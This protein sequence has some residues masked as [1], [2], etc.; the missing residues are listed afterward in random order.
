MCVF[1][2]NFALKEVYLCRA[3]ASTDE[4]RW[5]TKRSVVEMRAIASIALAACAAAQCSVRLIN[6]L[7]QSA[8]LST[9]GGSEVSQAAA[10]S[11]AAYSPVSCDTTSL[12]LTPNG[13]QAITV[14]IF[15]LAPATPAASVIAYT[16]G[17]GQAAGA[18]VLDQTSLLPVGPE[19]IDMCSVRVLNAASSSRSLLG[20]TAVCSLNCSKD[21]LGSSMAPGTATI[22]DTFFDCSSAWLY[23]VVDGVSGAKLAQDVKLRAYEHGA[24]T[25]LITANAAAGASAGPQLVLLVDAQPPNP[26]VPL[27]IALA[28][29]PA[30]FIAHCILG[31]L[32]AQC[33]ARRAASASSSGA[34]L[35]PDDM[36]AGGR[37]GGRGGGA[38]DD[39][40]IGIL[41]FLGWDKLIAK[42]TAA[43][44]ASSDAA[45]GGR[46]WGEGASAM[47]SSLLGAAASP[48]AAVNDGSLG[49]AGAASAA[50][51]AGAAGAS[52][53]A[54]TSTKP[55]SAG[56][57]RGIDA[58][59]GLSLSGMVFV[60]AGA[61]GYT[62]L[63][64]TPWNGLNLA[65][66]LFPTFVW[67]QG[68]SM[69]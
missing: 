34:S 3:T 58:L 35:S 37:K 41:A 45:G 12:T 25:L 21:A 23:D 64:H 13:G 65:D 44:R 40:T 31:R 39:G 9:P 10:H 11:Q 4:S 6:E 54:I 26:F 50:S 24:Y 5:K 57:V 49:M 30:L 22:Y 27:Y 7:P 68:V 48:F 17:A 36:S 51:G 55:K 42:A 53:A 43:A 61:G 1:V 69:A 60:N 2:A 66:V 38:K 33:I 19:F 20:V 67:S 18:S 52:S 59:R 63:D 47:H 29:L 16:N 8:S 32:V 15:G 56:R 46:L 14:Q 28:A 62:W